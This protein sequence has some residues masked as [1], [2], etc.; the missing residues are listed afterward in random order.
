[1]GNCC[2]TRSKGGGSGSGA[3]GEGAESLVR[4]SF[5]RFSLPRAKGASG[6]RRIAVA[7]VP[8]LLNTAWDCTL[9]AQEKTTITQDTFEAGVTEVT[10]NEL[11]VAI[12]PLII[13]ADEEM[14]RKRDSAGAAADGDP[15]GDL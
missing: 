2:A 3:P 14:E 7:D 15:A 1:M 4:S 11:I 8:M 12:K 5:S 6:P 10:C 9:T 13:K